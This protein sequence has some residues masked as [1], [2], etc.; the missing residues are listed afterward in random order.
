MPTIRVAA[1]LSTEELLEAVDQLDRQELDQF[2]TQVFVLWAQ[3]Q[4]PKLSAGEK[5]LI[6]KI[7]AGI[8]DALHERYKELVAKRQAEKLTPDEHTEL[9]SLTDQVEELQA[10]RVEAMVELAHRRNTSL[11]DLMKNLGLRSPAHG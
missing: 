7:K 1:Q 8:P 9:L 10:R 5:K 6:D 3:R 4:K 11:A 2:V